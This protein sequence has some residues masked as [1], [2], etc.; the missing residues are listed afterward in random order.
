MV[1]QYELYII[2][3]PLLESKE[4]SQQIDTVKSVLETEIGAT[5]L[6]IEEEGVRRMAYPI[7]KKSNGFYLL[8]N[9]DLALASTTKVS[10]LEQRFNVNDNVMRYLIINQ[11]EDVIKADKQVIKET[12]ITSHRDL[13]KGVKSKKCIVSYLGYKVIDYKDV[14]LL[15]QFTS[16]YA[17]IFGKDRTGSKSKYQRKISTAIKRARHMALMPFTTKHM[18][19]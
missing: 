1:Q 13:N 12:E 6:Q 9:F 19:V 15:E 14:E 8:I 2:L 18:E 5:N 16:P 4:I 7:K 17:K 10:L 11:T 3:N